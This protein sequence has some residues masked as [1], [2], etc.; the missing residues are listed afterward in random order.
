MT[1]DCLRDSGVPSDVL[2]L[3]VDRAAG[4]P[5][6]IEELLA[7][8]HSD[9]VLVRQGNRWVT[10]RP[11]RGCAPATFRESVRVRVGAMDPSAQDLLR[12]AALLGRR[13]HPD[14]VADVTGTD[15]PRVEEVLRQ[16]AD[17]ALVVS[18]DLGVRFRHA[19]VRD[20]LVADLPA[21]TRARRSHDVLGALRT[22]RPE[23]PDDLVEWPPIWPKPRASAPRPRSCCAR[24]ADVRST[25]ER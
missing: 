2:R 18:S 1:R 11:P 10:R 22:A 12:D 17:L 7:G 3:V 20:A 16:A 14:L 24:S 8:L 5:F 6:F 13:V 9:D 4:L 15:L 19:L 21:D 23:L 25:A